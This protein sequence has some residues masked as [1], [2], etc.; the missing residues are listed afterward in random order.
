[1]NT[2]ESGGLN[3]VYNPEYNLVY[4]SENSQTGLLFSC[5]ITYA[6]NQP[7]SLP[8]IQIAAPLELCKEIGGGGGCNS[9]IGIKR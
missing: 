3:F 4:E 9:I 7:S 6:G 8:L 5:Y 1:M 2:I